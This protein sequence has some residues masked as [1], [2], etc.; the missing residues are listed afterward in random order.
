MPNSDLPKERFL[1]EEMEIK[2]LCYLCVAQTAIYFASDFTDPMEMKK[3]L[4]KTMIG[5]IDEALSLKRER[6]ETT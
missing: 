5:I 6:K 3:K 1:F 2:A 4:G